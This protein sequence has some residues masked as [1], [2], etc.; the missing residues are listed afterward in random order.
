MLPLNAVVD[1]AVFA[2]DQDTCR[3]GLLFL[4]ELFC[5]LNYR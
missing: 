1:V 4:V 5:I 3:I 2:T